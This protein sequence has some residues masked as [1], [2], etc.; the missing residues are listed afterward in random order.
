MTFLLPLD[1]IDAAARDRV[2]KSAEGAKAGGRPFISFFNPEEITAM[3]LQAGFSQ[4]IHVT[5]EE[6][7]K[8]YF[9][10]RADSLRPPRERGELSC[11]N[12]L[13]RP[14]FRLATAWRMAHDECPLFG[15]PSP[16]LNVCNQGAKQTLAAL[17]DWPY[18]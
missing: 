3:A 5:G 6:L 15:S 16:W 9:S 10:G 8:R 1:L 14:Q 7:A 2:A 13:T 12:D 18:V 11:R 4:A 17:Q